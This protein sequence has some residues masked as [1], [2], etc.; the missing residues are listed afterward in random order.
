ML[1]LRL[2]YSNKTSAARSRNVLL[3]L[4]DACWLR[5]TLTNLYAKQFYILVCAVLDPAIHA[6]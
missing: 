5:C 6:G 4:D 2:C 3:A 1:W